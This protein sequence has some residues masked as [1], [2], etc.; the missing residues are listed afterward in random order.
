VGA[1]GLLMG[2]AQH[3]PCSLGKSFHAGHNFL[4]STQS[5]RLGQKRFYQ[6]RKATRRMK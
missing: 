4:S 5:G 6:K 1:L 3:P 2:Q